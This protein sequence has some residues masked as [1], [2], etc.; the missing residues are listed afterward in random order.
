ML[1]F[2]IGYPRCYPGLV[3]YCYLSTASALLNQ[4][5]AQKVSEMRR[6]F[7]Y[8]TI[9][10]RFSSR[11]PL[12]TYVSIQINFWIVANLLAM[13]I[14][15]IT[16]RVIGQTYKISVS[17]P[18]T[19]LL[20]IALFMGIFYGLILGPMHYYLDQKFF[21]SLPWEDYHT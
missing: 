9:A 11:F 12:V 5:I 4:M 13:S 6:K 3:R 15:H 7:D 8:T 19:P 16:S 14:M 18:F 17:G 2:R 10:H 21:K 1:L 20:L